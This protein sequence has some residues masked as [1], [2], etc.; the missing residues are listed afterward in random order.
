MM[1]CEGCGA[2]QSPADE[3]W[4][5]EISE[6]YDAY[7]YYQQA[8]GVEQHVMDPSLGTLRRRS[9]VLLDRLETLSGFPKGGSV[10]DIGCGGGGTLRAFATR[11]SWSLFGLEMNDRYRASLRSISGFDTLYTCEPRDLPRQFDLVT[12][13]HAVEHFPEPLSALRDLRFKIAP[14][15]RL[16]IEVP[17]A[18]AN[19]FEYL[20]ADHMVHFTQ[21]TLEALARGAG[22]SVECLATDWVSKELSLTARPSEASASP[23]QQPIRE[24]AAGIRAQLEW[25]IRLSD[26]ARVV[27]QESSSFGLFGSAIAASWLCGLL[28][29]DVSFFVE[30]DPNRVGRMHMGRPILS[31][32]QVPPGSAVFLALVPHIASQIAA[33]LADLPIKL[34]L[35]PE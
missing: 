35:S 19:P 15:G 28:G 14:G 32:A 34:R 2:A 9:D 20:I 30:E 5:Q 26:A 17:N 29:D 11:G 31:P 18:G 27:A 22:F 3:Q 24:V 25:L 12:M 23:V 1:I 4:F 16:F 8:G 13:V 33:R 6:I 7:Q 21:C 10:V